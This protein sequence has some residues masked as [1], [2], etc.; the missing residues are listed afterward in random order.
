MFIPG[1]SSH[2]NFCSCFII[3]DR[4]T[5]LS[6]SFSELFPTKGLYFRLDHLF[7]CFSFCFFLL[8]PL[9]L[10]ELDKKL[11]REK[12]DYDLLLFFRNRSWLPFL[13]SMF[14]FCVICIIFM[15]YIFHCHNAPIWKS[16]Q[17]ESPVLC[18]RR[19]RN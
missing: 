15:W 10:L 4:F 3:R 19:P 12:A 5:G 11:M 8:L 2:W 6:S 16:F 17:I 18:T 1:R 7:L 9:S 14:T 13:M